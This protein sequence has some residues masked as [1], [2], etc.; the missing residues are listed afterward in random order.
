VSRAKDQTKKIMKVRYSHNIRAETEGLQSLINRLYKTSIKPRLYNLKDASTVVIVEDENVVLGFVIV[1]QTIEDFLVLGNYQCINNTQVA[2]LLFE[3][4]KQLAKQKGYQK[5]LGPINGNTW[6]SYRFSIKKIRPFFL[7][8]IHKAYYL[9]Q[10]AAAG[11]Q[12]YANYYT[13][14]ETLGNYLPNE[15]NLNW[16]A[17]K[18]QLTVR[19]LNVEVA[20]NDLNLL[21]QFCSDAFANNLLYTSINQNA[22]KALYQPILPYLKKDLIDL[23]IKKKDT[24][25]S[26][27]GFLFAFE[28]MYNPQQLIAKTIAR[29]Q[30]DA[31][32][33]L[34]HFLV[35]RML[36]KAA[37]NG[38]TKL[39][40]AYMES[41]NKSVKM[42]QKFGGQTYQDH[43]LLQLSL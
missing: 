2:T 26:V 18:P 10:W 13:F 30:G 36:L 7:E 9:Q 41:S 40:H 11:F 33:G 43:Q 29:K 17:D 22:F 27:V 14:Q 31:Y 42:S 25:E 8:H 1:Y 21:H 4:I 20:E 6:H 34:A 23:V 37:N 35:E 39:L 15:K 24:A 19:H 28:D 12:P 5:L 16:L 38:Y 32:K 3:T